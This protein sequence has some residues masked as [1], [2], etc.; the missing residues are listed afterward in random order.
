MNDIARLMEEIAA[1]AKA[2]ARTLAVASAAQK[3]RALRAAAS[4]L[5]SSAASILAANDADVRQAS[6]EQPCELIAG[7]EFAGEYERGTLSHTESLN[8]SYAASSTPDPSLLTR[9]L[10]L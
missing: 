10:T 2:A 7:F 4:A 5:R 3:D 9:I 1:A 6:A 8:A